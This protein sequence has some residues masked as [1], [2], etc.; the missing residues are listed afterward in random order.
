MKTHLFILSTAL[1]LLRATSAL[2]QNPGDN[3]FA[4]I[5]VHTINIQFSQPNYWDSLTTYYNEQNEQYMAVTVI[6]DGVTYDSV[7][8][9]FK[10]N[11]SYTQI[12]GK[13][14]FRLSFD[15]YKGSQRWDGVK[16]IHLN[17]CWEDP[18]FMREK[19]HLDFCQTAGIAAPRANYASLFINNTLFGFYSMVEHVDKRFLGSHFGDSEGDL[20]KA[21]DVFSESTVSDFQWYGSDPAE[22]Y[23]R[24]E[25]KTEESL[26][27][28]PRLV[29]LVD[30][31][32][33]SQTPAISLRGRMNLNAFYKAIAADILFGN[34]DSYVDIGQNF[35]FYF[36]P[37][38]NKMEWIVWDAG[39][40][41]GGMPPGGGVPSVETLDIGFVVDPAT[42]PL[43]GKVLST[44]VLKN[45]YLR[46]FCAVF[47]NY[48]SS[49]QL[50]PRI[51][52]IAN[53]IR[54]FVYQDSRNEYSLQDFEDN[55]DRDIFV[56]SG[57]KPGLKSFISL[58]EVNVAGQLDSL[59]IS[60]S[61]IVSPGD[62]VI[63]EFMAQNDSILD[64]AGEP[65]DWIELYNN[66]P[67][68]IDLGGM[69]LSN[70][71]A[72]PTMWQFPANTKIGP[73]SY[74]IIWADDDAGQPGLHAS[75][76]LSAAG[77]YL[78]LINIDE[79]ILDE[80]TFGIQ[81][82]NR[83][84][85]RI[86]NGTGSFLQGRATFNANN[87]TSIVN[88]PA[89]TSIVLPQ[90]IEGINGTNA[91][92]IPFAFR[93]RLTG[94]LPG[95]TYRYTNQVVTS[96]DAAATNGSG[97]CIFASAAG[98]FVRTTGPS[99][100]TAGNFGTFGTD[101]SGAYEG[102]F[103]S[104]PTGN[105]RFVPS[106]YV[107]MRIMLNDGGSGTS[108]ALRLTT[109]DS[110]RVVK[111]DPAANDSC[112]TGLRCTSLSSPKDFVFLFDN[113]SG[114]GR[115]ISGSFVES[116][117]TANTTSNNYAAYY[118]NSVNDSSGA[119]GV[120]VPNHLPSGIR[121]IERRSLET[122]AII[123]TALDSD[124]VWPSG[125]NTVN[126]SGGTTEIVLSGTDVPLPIQLASFSGQFIEGGGV[127]LEWTTA[128]ELNSYGFFVQRRRES[129]A[130]WF[131]VPNSFVPGHGTTHRPH[132]YLFTDRTVGTGS[133]WYRLRQVDLDGTTH[134]S[135]PI[136]VAT[137]TSVDDRV[138]I[139]FS[140]K[141]NFPNPFNPTTTIA[142]TVEQPGLASLSVYNLLGQ[143]VAIPFNESATPG[144]RYDVT[145][146]P[147]QL[148][149]G[150]YFY[151]L[152]SGARSAIG[153]MLLMK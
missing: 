57:R 85:A 10:G 103:V 36:H 60:C 96:A 93:A 37:G 14:P 47:N 39:L 88:D 105:A 17:N 18:S 45:Q 153:K 108:V 38:T 6:A 13:K 98:D 66:T 35:Y 19:L 106:K 128:S 140:L 151:Q 124:G 126:P 73:D 59:G 74:L 91:N 40:S 80:V 31:L 3:I 76:M 56:G 137:L 12:N 131:E 132:D 25:L 97:N 58:R 110:V 62:V 101:A 122:G 145:F 95:A 7:G 70:N 146:R 92:R 44:P 77:D 46:T 90:Y 130:D 65:D 68:S 141:Q 78:S 143:Q 99:L 120:V 53:I 102:W 29:Q 117:G 72:A 67:D 23:D 24:Y 42:R 27:A 139:E 30:T 22:Y 150:V 87:G 107:F 79:S 33:N 109:S 123:D 147:G 116:D 118:S 15:K 142:F 50:H 86:P 133:W 84:M 83:A 69:Y 9:R 135:E 16:G 28:W 114:T 127:Q 136:A 115:P 94:L 148:P 63:N 34:L 2:G 113:T 111:L 48:F 82:A 119:F 52:T 4:G 41:F 104:E 43:F 55:I 149:S 138:P 21:V 89:L 81:T 144:K 125:T 32:N 51:D 20:F 54:P 61:V 100:S 64:G 8:V 11:A 129:T 5:Q 71:P 121:R 26:T 112:G 75:F 152:K 1:V 134:F 49:A